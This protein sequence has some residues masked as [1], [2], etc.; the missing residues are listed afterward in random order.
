MEKKEIRAIVRNRKKELTAE[1]RAAISSE[2][3]TKVAQHLQ[4]IPPTKVALFL[5]MPDEVDT[6]YLIS[7][8]REQ[9]KHTILVPRVEDEETIRFYKLKEVEDYEISNFGILE[10]KDDVSMAE[11]PSVMIVPG[12]AFD[13]QGGR[14]GRGRGYYDRYFELHKDVIKSKIAIAYQL[15]VM[16]EPVPMEPYDERMDALITEKGVY[17]F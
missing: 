16:D 7:K 5:S 11:V 2:V 8:L 14:V 12:V 3:A 9:G 6:S 17:R 10:P 15:Q 1:Q 13:M 4:E